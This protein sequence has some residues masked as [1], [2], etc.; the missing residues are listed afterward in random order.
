MHTPQVPLRRL[1]PPLH[2]YYLFVYS[3]MFFFVIS[4]VG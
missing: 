4:V 1:N 2:L 3:F